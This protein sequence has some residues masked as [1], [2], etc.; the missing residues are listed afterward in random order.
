MIREAAAG[1]AVLAVMAASTVTAAAQTAGQFERW[2]LPEPHRE[3]RVAC[4]D[5]RELTTYEFAIDAAS[6]VP[7]R[8]AVPEFCLV[9]GQIMPEVRFEIS[10]PVSWNGRLYMFGNG[11]YAGEPFS[12][13]LRVALRHQ[14]LA[15][16]FAVASTNTGHDAAREPL[17][18]FAINSQ[19]LID[20]AYRA[21]H[22]TAMTAK[23]IARGYYGARPERSYFDGC[24]TGGRQGLISAQRFPEDFDGIVV[25]APVLDFTGTM[26]HYAVIHQALS[27]APGLPAKAALV[28]RHVYRKCDAIDGASDGVIDD[29]RMCRI[30]PAA[31][32]PQCTSGDASDCLTP[33][34]TKALQAIYEPVGSSGHVIAPGFPAGTEI[35][36]PGP[37]GTA[38]SGWVP[39]F[40][41]DGPQGRPLT[42]LFLE[43][44]FRHMV[45]PGTEL[46]WRTFD[47]VR[48]AAKLRTIGTLL[49][50]TDTDLRRFRER[51]G[52]ILMYFGWAD[53]GLSPLMGSGYYDRV[54]AA[55]GPAT[56]DFFRLFMIPGMFHCRGGVGTDTVDTMT[57]LVNWVER[58]RAPDRLT[59]ARRAGRQ[60]VRTRPLCPYPQVA[61][62]SGSG[63]LD[64]EASFVCAAP[65]EP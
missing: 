6:V 38:R 53:A 7:A 49:N 56:D 51:G 31:D 2:D 64:D 61:R 60:D 34:E 17:G 57:P 12:A 62:Y 16:G 48:D 11:G 26:S 40:A 30:N 27:A 23:Q 39:W 13:P 54:R 19:K 63:S 46:D 15:R 47:P 37:G 41:A 24:S 1:L 10:L 22:V 42:L 55:M 65:R 21:V 4:A 18:S 8:A 25:G 58:G 33:G 45:S 29:P 52:K 43:S 32:V 3:P 5:L 35:A 14:A 44:F 59:A 36:A 28:A 20:Y 9:Q 50:A